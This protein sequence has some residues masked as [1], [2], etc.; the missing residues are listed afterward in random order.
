[1]K[2]INSF[3]FFYDY[4]NLMD[5]LPEEDGKDILWAIAKYMFKDEKP[6]LKGH[7]LA[8]FNTLSYQ[9]NISKNNAKRSMGNGAPKGN[10]N[11][12]KKQTKN[13]P[14]TNQKQT[15][16]V[17]ENKQNSISISYFYFYISNLNINNSLKEEI[18]KWLD[19]KTERKEYYKETGFKTL[20]TR[21]INA[22][23]KYGVE[24]MIEVIEDC[25]SSNY[26]G[27]IFEK[28]EKKPKKADVPSWFNMDLNPKEEEMTE[29]E[30]K[31]YEYITSGD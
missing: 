23:E 19:Y 25:I 14:E 28:L 22:S 4:F 29:E 6:S 18:K 17:T 20:V 26:K 8:I 9:L 10:Q 13:K 15:G 16:R 30:K 3:T 11:A 21:I 24:N 2:T 27:I 5:T 1:M 12:V 7:N 31:I